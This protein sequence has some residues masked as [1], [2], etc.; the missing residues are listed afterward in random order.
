MSFDDT[1][2]FVAVVRAQ[3]FTRAGEKLGV[4]K[5][6]LSRRVA[7]LEQRLATRLLHRTTRKLALTEV[8][9]AYFARCLRAVEEI[10][11]AERVVADV[12]AQ[13]RGLLRVSTSFDF[14]RDHLSH[15]LPEFRRRYPDVRLALELTQH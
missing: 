15:W 5:A 14:A 11:D 10:E 8:G 4:P 2:A 3:S 13:P 6:T 12:T 7:R 1:L 9:E